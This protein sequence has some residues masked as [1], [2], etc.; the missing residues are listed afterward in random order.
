MQHAVAAG[1]DR[2]PRGVA[3]FQNAEVDALV[4]NKA[5]YRGH[6]FHEKPIDLDPSRWNAISS[7]VDEKCVALPPNYCSLGN[8]FSHRSEPYCHLSEKPFHFTPEASFS[9]GR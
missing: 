7:L 5:D 6:R 2:G 8:C 3:T 4:Y 9:C 1:V